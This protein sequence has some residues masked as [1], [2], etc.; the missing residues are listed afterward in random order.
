MA[1]VSVLMPHP[2]LRE[3]AIS[4]ID[5]YP[6][7]EPIAIEYVQTGQISDRA[8]MLEREGCDLIVAR[9]LQAR[10]ARDSVRIPIIEMR[11]STQELASQVLEMKH[12]LSRAGQRPCIGIIGFFNMFHSTERF[13][14]IL[15]VD[16]RVYVATD[17]EQ[18]AFLV[19]CAR[20]E[21]CTGVIG[22]EQVGQRAMQL[23]LA[24]R[25][26]SMGEESIREAFEAA[27]LLGYSIDL[28]RRSDAE[29]NAM[30][31]NAAAG[32]IQVNA[33][34]VIQRANRQ[35][36][37]LLGLDLEE[38]IGREAAAVIPN[39]PAE[40]FQ[41][42]LETGAN[43]DAAVLTLNQ[44]T[45]LMN[46]TPVLD[47]SRVEGA[48]CTFQ[49]G[50]RISE[51]DSRLRQEA[52]RRGQVA[53]HTFSDLPGASEGF[54]RV[55]S[56]A[57]RL[58]RTSA[59]VLLEGESGVGKGW[60]AECIHNESRV[61]GGAFV[62]VD[63]AAWHPEDLEGLLF[64]GYSSRSDVHCLVE[65]AEQ[66][67]LYLRHIE[68]LSP[69]LQYRLLLLTRGAFLRARRSEAESVSVRL[70]AST[71]EGLKARVASGE[72]RQDLY[73]AFASGRLIVP[74]LRQRPEDIPLWLKRCLDDCQRRYKRFIT[75]T[76]EA[77]EWLEQQSW[78]GNLNQMESFCQR[79]VLLS[80]KRTVTLDMVHRHMEAMEMAPAQAEDAAV[81]R[82]P[83]A[84]HLMAALQANSGDRRRTA[85]EMGISTTTLWRRM[86][87]LGITRDLTWED[88]AR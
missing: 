66:G 29:M 30:L 70:V 48:I 14:E 37:S 20:G 40:E 79:M 45:V 74:P 78:P 43:I 88:G 22:G 26:L 25:F 34:G 76:R 39:L 71:G 17:I 41:R 87:R 33:G 59:C 55:L 44:A 47:E 31:D 10:I 7:I 58:A 65:Q 13:S 85:D 9:G 81:Y 6:R 50:V 61:R 38:V 15:G 62:A 51:M 28:H 21:G 77:R 27:S 86:R 67:T 46:M 84:L 35:C 68:A 53:R 2:E 56:Q 73:Y 18:Y 54:S 11:A 60:L 19:D 42:A 57:R 36:I 12:I 82:S 52:A 83:E 75:V 72:F 16:L 1:K 69:E 64:G 5:Q 8:R 32:I 63:C 49:E 80:E 23:G 24:Y 3:L 4:L